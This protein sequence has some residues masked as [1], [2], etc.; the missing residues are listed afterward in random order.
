VSQETNDPKK[1]AATSENKTVTFDDSEVARLRAKLERERQGPHCLAG[2][3]L[4]FHEFGPMV[5]LVL[6]KV[7]LVGCIEALASTSS[8][9]IPQAVTR[10]PSSSVS[11]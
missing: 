8:I 5:C 6:R 2:F 1:G 11:L 7:D 3:G 9:G 10:I 4:C